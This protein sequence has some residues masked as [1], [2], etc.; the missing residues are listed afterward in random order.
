VAVG[1]SSATVQAELRA[2]G[3]LGPVGLNATAT[4]QAQSP[5][6]G[7]GDTQNRRYC[8]VAR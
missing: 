6:G 4:L 8:S 1:A 5:E 7:G 3:A 2:T